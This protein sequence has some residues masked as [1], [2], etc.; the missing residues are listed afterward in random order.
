MRDPEQGGREAAVE[1]RYAF[2]GPDAAKGVQR[3]AVGLFRAGADDA[4]CLRPGQRC[5]REE[6]RRE[7]RTMNRVLMT[8]SGFVATVEV[9]PAVTAA[10]M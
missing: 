7:R 8:Q 9:A 1:P 3:V 4:L 2:F 5:E 10:A 6:A